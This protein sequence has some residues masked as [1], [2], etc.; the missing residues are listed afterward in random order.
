MKKEN[1]ENQIWHKHL[2]RD[3]CGKKVINKNEIWY[4]SFILY[5]DEKNNITKF[6]GRPSAWIYDAIKGVKNYLSR[7]KNE[8]EYTLEFNDIKLTVNRHINVEELTK[9]YF[10]RYAK[11]HTQSI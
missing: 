5:K 7:T 3:Y 11:D 4:K 8:K 2:I 10:E 1:N 6:E 9:E